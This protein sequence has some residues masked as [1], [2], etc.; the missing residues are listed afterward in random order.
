MLYDPTLYLGCAKYYTPGR[1]P[2]SLHLAA[3]LAAEA[4]LDGCG[5]LLDVG[6]GPGP[7]AIKLADRFGEVIGLDP[8]AG[9]LAEARLR[10]ATRGIK[11]IRWMQSQAEDIGMLGI[12][13]CR[14]ITFGQSFHWTDR[15][16]VA[17]IAYGLLE[18][19]G[20]V[21]LINQ[22]VDGRPRPKGP[23]FPAIP[24]EAIRAIIEQYLGKQRRAGN[25]FAS[26]PTDSHSE[27]LTSAGSG[28]R[29][30]Y[31]IGPRRYCSGRRWRTRQ[32]PV[33]LVCSASPL[34]RPTN[35]I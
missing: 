23:G 31:C 30:H 24:H 6:C 27:V 5:H 33:D 1:P 18:P 28:P 19:S 29:T 8:D 14:L 22:M 15:D 10:A 4:G 17:K 25:G 9:M 35:E 3:T 11:N 7:L 2:Y 13:P 34:R 26:L 20:A 16:S 32:L 12:G 21:A